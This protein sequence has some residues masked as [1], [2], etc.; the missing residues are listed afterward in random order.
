MKKELPLVTLEQAKK[1][2]RLGFNWDTDYSHPMTNQEYKPIKFLGNNVF[3]ADSYAIPTVAL[4]LMWLRDEKKIQCN[5]DTR[6][7]SSI[8]SF[9]IFDRPN[10]DRKDLFLEKVE[11]FETHETAASAG[12]SSALDYLIIQNNKNERTKHR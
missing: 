2:R 3:N 1:L 9:L 12:L 4:A 7:E 11:C 6:I 8:Y 5:I 10:D